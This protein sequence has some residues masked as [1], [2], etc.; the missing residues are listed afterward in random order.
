MLNMP[1]QYPWLRDT[2][3]VEGARFAR[4]VF[5]WTGIAR[6]TLRVFDQFKGRYDK[7]QDNGD[8]DAPHHSAER[9]LRRRV[10]R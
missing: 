7:Y 2:L 1:L 9:P 5:G 3:V 10:R 8:D 4:R 6:R